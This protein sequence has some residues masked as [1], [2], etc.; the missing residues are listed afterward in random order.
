MRVLG[1]PEASEEAARLE[2]GSDHSDQG[3]V[4]LTK[5]S[6]Y[7]SDTGRIFLSLEVFCSVLFCPGSSSSCFDSFDVSFSLSPRRREGRDDGKKI[8]KRSIEDS[9]TVS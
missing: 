8:L 2:H 1:L 4:T 6:L 5:R 9:E 7:F 3:T